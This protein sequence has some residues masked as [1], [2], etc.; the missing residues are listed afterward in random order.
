MKRNNFIPIAFVVALMLGSCSKGA[1]SEPT[2]PTEVPVD[3]SSTIT[4]WGDATDTNS[5]TAQK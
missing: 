5:G 2:P 3:A 1:D 4:D